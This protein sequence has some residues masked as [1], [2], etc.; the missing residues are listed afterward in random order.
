MFRYVTYHMCF[1]NNLGIRFYGIL[2]FIRSNQKI[3]LLQIKLRFRRR[4]VYYSVLVSV[5]IHNRLN[6]MT[7]YKVGAGQSYLLD[8]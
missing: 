5:L 2:N 8:E 4:Y 3:L 6:R 1:I 7:G